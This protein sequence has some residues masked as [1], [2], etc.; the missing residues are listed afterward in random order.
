MTYYPQLST[1]ALSQYPI[2][3]RVS[4][5]TIVNELEDGSRVALA[6]ANAASI[7]WEMAYEGLSDAEGD[8]LLGFFADLEGRLGSFTFFDPVGNLA[9]WSE[10]LS[11]AAWQKN[12]LLSVAPAV[13]D[14]LGSTRASTVT[15]TGS[16]DLT[17]GQELSIPGATTCCWSF[18]ARCNAAQAI[19]LTRTSGSA[20]ASVGGT[21][22]PDWR[23]FELSSNLV[24]SGTTSVFEL[25]LHAGAA[26]DLFGFQVDAQPAASQYVQTLAGGGVYIAARFDMDEI[27]I[28]SAGPNQNSCTL[29]LITHV[30]G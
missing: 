8:T 28:I 19:A 30:N 11:A 7:R 22:G 25:T 27:T 16:G 21:A 6:D 9:G 10:T 24:G 26:L 4:H 2:K 1:G 18:Y 20:S 23:R 15:N 13:G 12:G 17:F 14:P 5:R 3:K 29:Q